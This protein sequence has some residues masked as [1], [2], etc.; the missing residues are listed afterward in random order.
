MGVDPRQVLA[1]VLT[2]TM[3]VMLGDMV[4]RDH[5]DSLPVCHFHF[6]ILTSST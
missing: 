5:F 6:H 1:G 2:I 4:K 3:F